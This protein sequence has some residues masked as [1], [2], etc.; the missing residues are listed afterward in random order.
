MA[1]KIGAKLKKAFKIKEI[2]NTNDA[3]E[4]FFRVE[5]EEPADTVL[6]EPETSILE[7]SKLKIGII[8]RKLCLQTN[9][10]SP[11]E[12]IKDIND[13]I[14]PENS[15]EKRILYS[16][17]SSFVYLIQEDEQGNFA[18]NIER[19]IE[20]SLNQDHNVGNDCYRIIIKIYD[21]FHLAIRQKDLNSTTQE[22]AT[23]FFTQTL[24]STKK[25]IKEEISKSIENEVVKKI[26][27]EYITILG[28][29]S[30]VVLAFV[31]DLTFTSSVLENI[32]KASIYRISFI[33]CLLGITI[34]DVIFILVKFLYDINEGSAEKST[35]ITHWFKI[36]NLAGLALCFIIFAM[37]LLDVTG[38]KEYIAIFLPWQ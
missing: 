17:I 6:I 30:S 11:D 32:H 1:K 2:D 25:E 29:F 22:I 28:I 5:P 23:K 31:A 20:Y 19:L 14:K 8:C 38:L 21:H 33:V 16:E 7:S 3:L 37:W 15:L 13:Y 36:I 12:I 10:F 35:L 4:L 24:D 18:T 9:V 34:I 27:K 26:E